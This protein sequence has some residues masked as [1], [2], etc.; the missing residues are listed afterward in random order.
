MS[1]MDNFLLS[2]TIMWKGMLGIFA[3]LLI[4]M[5]III[6]LTKVTGKDKK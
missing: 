4:L 5:V 6:I 1:V 3:V 2:L